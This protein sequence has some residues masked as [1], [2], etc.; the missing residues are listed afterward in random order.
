M[1]KNTLILVE[2]LIF[3]LFAV[4]IV[5]TLGF[6]KVIDIDMSWLAVNFGDKSDSASNFQWSVIPN[7]TVIQN[8]GSFMLVVGLGVGIVYASISMV[9][10]YL[11]VNK[12]ILHWSNVGVYGL[13]TLAALLGVLFL[14]VNF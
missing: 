10:Y 4:W 7:A 3:L 1:K 13:M 6:F 11:G 8:V 5:F 14:A 12:N 2:F 9:L